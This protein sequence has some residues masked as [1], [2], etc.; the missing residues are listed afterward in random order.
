MVLECEFVC[1]EEWCLRSLPARQFSSLPTP[2]LK[3]DNG[4]SN[5]ASDGVP[6]VLL[7]LELL[8]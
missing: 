7:G 1:Q 2:F 3:V 6:G 5:G 4:G 8:V